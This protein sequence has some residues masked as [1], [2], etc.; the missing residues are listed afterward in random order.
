MTEP[1]QTNK[2]QV[3]TKEELSSELLPLVQQSEMSFSEIATEIF[4]NFIQVAGEN[5]DFD[6]KEKLSLSI[7]AAKQILEAQKDWD[8]EQ[9]K[10]DG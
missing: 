3:V 10:D 8:R 1:T 5:Y 4:C 9:E 6:P 2:D 7:S